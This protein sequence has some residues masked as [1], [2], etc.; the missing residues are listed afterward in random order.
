MA[1]STELLACPYCNAQMPRPAASSPVICP[2]CGEAF[3]FRAATDGEHDGLAASHG[4]VITTGTTA[5]ELPPSNSPLFVRLAAICVMVAIAS[6]ALKV[7]LP[8]N[9]TTQRAFPF[10]LLM[11]GLGL[12]ASLWLWFL[13]K[14][15]ANATIALFVLV[16][17]AAVSLMILPYAL[18]T[19]KSRRGND[20]R[21]VQP[22]PSPAKTTLKP[23]APELLAGL[24]YLPDD[25]NLVA[26]IHVAELLATPQGAKLLARAPA[27][28]GESAPQLVELGLGQVEKWTGLKADAIDHVV[29]A[30]RGGVLFPHAMIVVRTL[31]DY[32]PAK[33]EKAQLPAKPTKHHDRDLYQVA[34]PPGML[35]CADPRTLVLLIR[36]DLL[37]ER[38]VEL[39]TAKLRTGADGPPLSIRAMVHQRLTVGTQLWW[40]GTNLKQLS[41]LGKPLPLPLPLAQKNA[42]LDKLLQ[43][44]TSVV[45]ALQLQ[46]DEAK[47]VGHVECPDAATARKVAKLLEAQKLEGL[48]SPTV[49]GPPPDG[50]SGWVTFQYNGSPEAVLSA[51]RSVPFLPPLGGKK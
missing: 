23:V 19:E 47:I 9:N 5:S 32:D 37:P 18:M 51:L 36:P 46:K 20:P 21:G 28:E 6:L 24:G 27:G 14:P 13:R 8:D 7:A 40:A 15:R 48:G 35:Y 4:E 30:I 29:L 31:K 10:M 49:A 11:S 50:A 33:V 17:M 22:E 1:L 3:R 12:V 34:N 2:R 25:C 45:V 41:V 26:G 43:N 38:D 42:E 44:V 39:V 16:N